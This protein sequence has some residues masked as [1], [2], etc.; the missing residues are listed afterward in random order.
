MI[1]RLKT[2]AATAAILAITGP[3]LAHHVGEMWQAGDVVVSHAW[4]YENAEMEHAMN[5]YLSLD[6]QGLSADKL[7]AAAAS[8]ADSTH[9]QAQVLSADGTL[10]L[11]EI[12]AIQVNPGQALTLQPG[13]V[14]IELES[15][16][17][18]FEHGEHFDLVLTFENSGTVE[19]EVEVEEEDDHHH[20]PAA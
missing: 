7:V 12:T 17:Q 15:V 14:W 16:H 1:E 9:F 13:A 3:V 20:K 11:R 19:I 5:V 2:T 18:T 4:T 8:F 6:N 10:E